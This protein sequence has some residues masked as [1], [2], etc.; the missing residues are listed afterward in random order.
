VDDSEVN[1]ESDRER[2]K[3]WK[4]YR[5][6]AEPYLSRRNE[7]EARLQVYRKGLALISPKDYPTPTFEQP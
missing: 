4:D 5:E 6:R 7:F 3:I 1:Q 2:D